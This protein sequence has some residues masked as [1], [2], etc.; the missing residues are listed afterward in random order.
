MMERLITRLALASAAAGG[1]VLV[2]L[3]VMTCVS[4]TG[5]ALIGLG[6]GPVP[7][8][9][10]LLEAGI[11][12]AVFAFLPLCQL[13]A[14]HA[15]V[16]VFTS[17]MPVGVNRVLLAVWEILAAS[18]LA[19]IAWRLGA[20]LA[21]KIGNGETTFLLQFPVWWAYAACMVPAVVAVIVAVWSAGDRVRSVVTGRDTR[22]VSA[23]STH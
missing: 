23:E 17:A 8:D 2:A 12:F 16:D 18:V 10:E 11:A 20:G 4:I 13:R 5:R 3:V 22:P 1:L 14:G 6:L 9:F 21:Q 7:G 19:L 15:T